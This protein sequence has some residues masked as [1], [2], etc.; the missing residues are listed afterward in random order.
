MSIHLS[1]VSTQVI[2]Y[3]IDKTTLTVKDYYITWVFAAYQTIAGHD[4]A[5]LKSLSM[6]QNSVLTEVLETTSPQKG[7]YP[8]LTEFV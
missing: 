7:T 8:D 5:R 2:N 4:V 3:F 6:P 1:V